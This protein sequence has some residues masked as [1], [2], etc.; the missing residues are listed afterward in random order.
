[1]SINEKIH[2]YILSKKEEILKEFFDV[3]KIPSISD[4]PEAQ[5]AL[6]HVKCLYE[7]NGFSAELYDDYLL[8][9][10]N[11]N[12]PHKIGLF[13][14]ADVVPVD[15]RWTVTS[16][17]EPKLYDGCIFARGA[18][19][20]KSA[21]LISLY[22]MKAI[23]ELELPFNSSIVAFT[24]GNEEGSMQDVKNYAKAHTPPNFSLVLDAAFPVHYGDKGMLWLMV[25]KQ[26]KLD[27]LISLKGGSA[28]N[29]TLGE[30]IAKVK[31]SP[32]LEREL[33]CN[34]NLTVSCQNGEITIHAKGI[35]SHGA[36]P[37]GT[38]NAGGVILSALLDAKSFSASDKEKLSLVYKALSTFD[39]ECIGIKATD[40]IFGE[41]TAS[42][43]II[44]ISDGKISFSLDIRHGNSYKQTELIS[45]LEK[46]LLKSGF[47][48]QI[49]KDGDA[50]Y[51]DLSNKYIGACLKSYK[52]HTGKE[53]APRIS[54][55]STYLRYVPNSC[56]VGTT[57]KYPSCNLP[58]GHGFAHQPNEHIS[59]DGFLE[60]IEIIIKMILE[61]DKIA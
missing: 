24:G 15:E 53:E 31:Y 51:T 28:F 45:H 57:T 32:E 16:P 4:T 12:A 18:L 27:S 9:Y 26:E 11:E 46:E 47:S 42:N 29:I 14:H 55:G 36:T 41:T 54:L 49:H 2:N 3:L 22:A 23:K 8:S 19:D 35:S 40:P 52:E 1:M 20:D 58:S 43:G 44:D 38:V 25:S 48:F 61:C 37:W 5:E 59:V 13:A 60:A 7:K 50:C 30:A 33:L 21:I 34:S 39:G 56:E 17:F 10:Y 6:K